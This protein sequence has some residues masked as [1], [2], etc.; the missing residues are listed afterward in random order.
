MISPKS[1]TEY[2][3]VLNGTADWTLL[4]LE[5]SDVGKGRQAAVRFIHE[6]AGQSWCDDLEIVPI[7]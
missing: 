5:T 1:D 4:E 2:S 3:R 7:P 6:G